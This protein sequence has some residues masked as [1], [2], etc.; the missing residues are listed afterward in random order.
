[1]IVG[2]IREY[3]LMQQEVAVASAYNKQYLAYQNQPQVRHFTQYLQR[4]MALLTAWHQDGL[5]NDQQTKFGFELEFWLA[6][7]ENLPDPSSVEFVN[8]LQHQSIITEVNAAELELNGKVYPIQKQLFSKLENDIQHLWDTC[9]QLAKQQQLHLL[10]CGSFPSGKPEHTNQNF[11]TPL[12][13]YYAIDNNLAAL[14]F[15]KEIP[16]NIQGKEDLHHLATCIAVNGLSGSFQIHLQI[17]TEKF[18]RY[19]NTSLILA[20]PLL[21]ISGNS[22]YFLGKNCWQESRIATFE[23][24][25]VADLFNHGGKFKCCNF[26]NGY[27]TNDWLKL[28]QENNSQYPVLISDTNESM[29]NQLHHLRLQNS[30][31]YRWSRPIIDFDEQGTPHLRIEFRALP[32]GP[33]ITDMVANAVFYVGLIEYLANQTTPP[34]QLLSFNNVRANFY[35]SAQYGM[36]NPLLWTDGGIWPVNK[37]ILKKLIPSAKSGL[38]QLGIRTDDINYYL[39]VIQQ[40][41]KQNQTGSLWQQRFI[42][43]HGKDFQAL[44]QAYIANQEGGLPVHEWC[45]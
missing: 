19:Y 2:L 42:A 40:R 32:A 23:Q 34:E 17:P 16:I 39:S 36:Q 45:F 31:T 35:R 6:T 15:Q 14:R 13:R 12:S 24:V 27:L 44:V 38:N 4:E 21:A 22:P 7:Q 18:I 33:T 26:G 29:S 1:M 41:V 9:L 11:L 8:R 3:Q 5:F 37:L 10:M 30:V 28:F 20:A 25:M 43:K